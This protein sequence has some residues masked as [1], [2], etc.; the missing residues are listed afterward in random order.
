MLR[1][2]LLHPRETWQT[3]KEKRKTA[4]L[5]FLQGRYHTFRALLDD[6]NRAVSL[7]TDLG[8][9]LRNE[10][11]DRQVKEA[12]EELLDKEYLKAALPELDINVIKSNLNL[13]TRS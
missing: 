11:I 4:A 10:N 8:M 9:K 13:I 1:Q 12:A 6:N 2:W 7:L 5:H 3:Q